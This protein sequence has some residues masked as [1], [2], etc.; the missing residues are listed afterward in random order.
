[1]LSQLNFVCVILKYT[2]EFSQENETY[3]DCREY[4]D[5]IK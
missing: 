3:C 1:M 5:G 4:V 2:A